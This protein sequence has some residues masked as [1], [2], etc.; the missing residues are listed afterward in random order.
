M[1]VHFTIKET[2]YNNEMYIL[3]K[4]FL[5]GK[6]KRKISLIQKQGNETSKY[7]KMK[8]FLFLEKILPNIFHKMNDWTVNWNGLSIQ[9]KPNERRDV[10]S[11][12]KSSIVI[13]ITILI[14]TSIPSLTQNTHQH[15]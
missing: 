10:C 15:T 1:K 7:F 4:Q 12:S 5:L 9:E 14:I 3:F 13:I 2:K 6:S 8:E 11:A